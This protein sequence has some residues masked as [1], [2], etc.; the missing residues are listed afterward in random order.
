MSFL[1]SGIISLPE[2]FNKGTPE[3]L[4]NALN[5]LFL[6]LIIVFYIASLPTTQVKLAMIILYLCITLPTYFC[7]KKYF[8][9]EMLAYN[10]KQEIRKLKYMLRKSCLIEDKTLLAEIKFDKIPE[11]TFQE[12]KHLL[13][14]YLKEESKIK[15]DLFISTTLDSRKKAQ[16]R[17]KEQLLT[18]LTNA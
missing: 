2:H 1:S 10:K 14:T 8:K 11:N 6:N 4:W 18:A 3:K 7:I 15:Q 17:R 13:E 9:K 16:K 12:Y 5:T